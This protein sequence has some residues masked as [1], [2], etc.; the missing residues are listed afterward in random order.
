MLSA[1]LS[2]STRGAVIQLLRTQV[3]AGRLPTGIAN[4]G[5]GARALFSG[6]MK[7]YFYERQ[8]EWASLSLVLGPDE[9]ILL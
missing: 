4:C 3:V 6:Q 2:R 1:T 8:K 5:W 7:Q 9:P